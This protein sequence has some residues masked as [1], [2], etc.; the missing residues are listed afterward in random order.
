MQNDLHDFVKDL[1]LTS[2][3]ISR[4]YFK[5]SAIERLLER[6]AVDGSF[7]KE[8]FSLLTL[9]L[10]HIEFMDAPRFELQLS[11]A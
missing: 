11:E 8:V 4:G 10:W 9:E 6:N 5:K 1:L 3:S 2:R 7:M